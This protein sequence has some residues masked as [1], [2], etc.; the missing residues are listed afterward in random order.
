M[1]LKAL[2]V[3]CLIS[4]LPVSGQINCTL[5]KGQMATIYKEGCDEFVQVQVFCTGGTPT[6]AGQNVPVVDITFTADVPIANGPHNLNEYP[7][8]NA[9]IDQ[10][11]ESAQKGFVT[12]T[13]TGV[14]GAGVNYN[15]GSVPNTTFGV[16][17][18]ENS[19]TFRFPLDPSPNGHTIT[20]NFH[21]RACDENGNTTDPFPLF[22]APVIGLSTD[23]N[24]ERPMRV[25]AA[26]ESVATTTYA[27]TPSQLNLGAD[28]NCFVYQAI[29][30]SAPANN[31]LNTGL[32]GSSPSVP[33]AASAT[34]NFSTL[35]PDCLRVR[36]TGFQDVVGQ[37][38]N[39]DLG[40]TSPI[41]P[42]IYAN[43]GTELQAVFN[44]IPA[45]VSVFVET[46][47]TNAVGTVLLTSSG[48]SA[49][50]TGLTQ[51]PVTNGTATAIWETQTASITATGTFAIPVYF[52]YQSGVASPA[53]ITVV[54]SLG[55]PPGGVQMVQ[56]PAS[57]IQPVVFSINTGASTTPKLTATVDSRPCI[58]GVTF[59]TNN[60]CTHANG[61][62]VSVVS[63]SASVQETSITFTTAGGLTNFALTPYQTTPILSQIFPNA[64]NATPG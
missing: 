2:Y 47:V 32:L 16:R 9:I 29:A 6:P 20:V 62:F 3:L 45:G 50:S 34:L 28:L 14:G 18:G 39:T 53:H 11:P 44:N 26:P 57:L 31:A 54:Q 10:P 43:Y 36:A 23:F 12:G 38:Y 63:D 24:N 64:T 7:G 8:A 41:V 13:V 21:I 17:A 58:L 46:S 5:K 61:L 37:F 40:F 56:P 52:A 60:A 22:L 33:S 1:R 30:G 27:I 35:F 55:S 49:G 59:W 48:T 19:V 51:I 42:P 15:D 4:C 25:G